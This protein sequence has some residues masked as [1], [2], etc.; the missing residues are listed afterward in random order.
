[1]FFYIVSVSF[2]WVLLV[3]KLT[4]TSSEF[5]PY[6][7]MYSAETDAYKTFLNKHVRPDAPET[8]D[9]NQWQAFIKNIGTCDR[10]IQSFIP[11]A[12]KQQVDNVCSPSGGKIYTGDQCVSKQEFTFTTVFVDNNCVVYNVLKETKYLLLACDEIQGYCRPVHFQRN[13]NNVGP[14]NKPDCKNPYSENQA[15]F[16]H[17]N[18]SLLILTLLSTAAILFVSAAE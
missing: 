5:N 7:C 4:T 3:N 16:A 9:Q 18:L 10:P 1:M 13:Q 2:F 11:F 14:Y 6:P 17:V 8:L 15:Q 12:Q